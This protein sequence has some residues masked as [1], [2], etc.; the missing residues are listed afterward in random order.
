MAELTLNIVTPKCTYGPFQCDSVHLTLSN[1]VNEKGGGSC[2]IRKE[3]AKSILSL[4]KGSIKAFN[5]KEIVLVGESG[6]GF[7]TVDKNI[8]TVVVESFCEEK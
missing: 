7:A 5:E 1:D 8:V 3:H 4:D 2:G 6:C